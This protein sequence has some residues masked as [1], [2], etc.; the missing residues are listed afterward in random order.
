VGIRMQ[1]VRTEIVHG[2]GR[3][4]SS[5]PSG[6]SRDRWDSD[7]SPAAFTGSATV[8]DM[9]EFNPEVDCSLSGAI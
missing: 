1:T 3:C 4:V 8:T 7:E 2:T 9:F 6:N 5:Y